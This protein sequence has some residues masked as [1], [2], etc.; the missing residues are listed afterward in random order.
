M[1]SEFEAYCCQIVLQLLGTRPLPQSLH[2]WRRVDVKDQRGGPSLKYLAQSKGDLANQLELAAIAV[3]FSNQ[4]KGAV[5][6]L[7]DVYYQNRR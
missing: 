2:A 6:T 4:Q 1:T 5:C 7:R 3:A